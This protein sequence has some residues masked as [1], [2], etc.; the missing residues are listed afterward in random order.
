ME[1]ILSQLGG[2][3]LGAVPTVILLITLMVLYK[4]I[5]HDKLVAVLGE[6]RARTEGAVQKAKADLAAAEAKTAEYE[7][8]LRE[9]KMALYKIQEA[10]RK[11]LL[12]A[13]AATIAD[14][15]AA[16][17]AK[18]KEARAAI[19]KDMQTARAT[20]ASESE[21]LAAEIVRAVLAPPGRRAP[22]AGG[23]R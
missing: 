21:K 5:L 18:V 13:R 16:A 2:L 17:D 1:K 15:K 3:L 6:R 14:A 8:R 23:A 4:L 10:R 12:E 7:N 19:E 22:A 20:L 11:Q 9:A